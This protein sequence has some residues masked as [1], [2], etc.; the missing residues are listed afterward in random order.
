[1]KKELDIEEDIEHERIKWKVERIGW[2]ILLVITAAALAGLLGSGPFSS[3]T[4]ENDSFTLKYNSIERYESPTTLEID[5]K[6]SPTS[7][8]SVR[9]ND[10]FLREIDNLQIHPEPK[11]TY[12]SN[13]N[14]VFVF[15]KPENNNNSVSIIFQLQH[16]SSG[17]KPLKVGINE[18]DLETNQIILP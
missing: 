16:S 14:S 7:E 10:Q 3:R 17:S 9:I 2:I 13:N 15:D 4:L 6:F 12:I 8:F 5:T 1:M 18:D 11:A